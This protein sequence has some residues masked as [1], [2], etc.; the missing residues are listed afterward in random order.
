[1]DPDSGRVCPG[2]KRFPTGGLGAA[3]AAPL[4]PTERRAGRKLSGA[5][6]ARGVGALAPRARPRGPGARRT[7]RRGGEKSDYCAER[8]ASIRTTSP[9]RRALPG[10]PPH[11]A[12]P[13]IPKIPKAKLQAG[14]Q[15]FGNGL[16]GL[17]AS[18]PHSDTRVAVKA[19]RPRRWRSLRTATSRVPGPPPSVFYAERAPARS[20]SPGPGSGAVVGRALAARRGS[21]LLPLLPPRK[22]NLGPARILRNVLCNRLCIGVHGTA[23]CKTAG[24][25]ALE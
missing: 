14:L 19:E 18:S 21:S 6:A 25:G 2:R 16:A 8:G 24:F 3:A 13:K 7:G 1:M 17:P 15:K 9:R 4:E 12:N 22:G 20:R 10:I 23:R 5:G 11:S